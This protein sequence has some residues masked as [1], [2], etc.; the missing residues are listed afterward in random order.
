MGSRSC[1]LVLKSVVQYMDFLK[2]RYFLL[3]LITGIFL[4]G[5]VSASDKKES[6]TKQNVVS[7]SFL[8][9]T[10]DWVHKKDMSLEQKSEISSYS[11]GAY[12]DPSVQHENSSL[13]MEDS[14]LL[15]YSLDSEASSDSS[16]TLKGD[17]QISQG[18]R[19]VFADKALLDQ[20]RRQVSLKGNV[21]FR[22]PGLLLIGDRANIDIDNRNVVM[23]NLTYV[24]HDASL[25]GTAEKLNRTDQGSIIIK[26]ASYSTCEPGDSSWKLV[27]DQIEI[28]QE[29][30]WA[31]IKNARLDVAEIPVFFF[32]YLKVPIN[33]RRV[34]GFLF[35]DISINNKNG[36]DIT[37]PI[38][39]NLAPNYD[40]I[41]SPRI[42]ER[43]GFGLETDLRFLNQWSK[44]T[45]SG[46]F[47]G[48]DRGG[49]DDDKIDPING[50]RPFEGE[51]RYRLNLKHLGG[52]GREWTSYVDFNKVSDLEY[53]RDFGN[54]SIDE[55]SKTHLKQKAYLDYKTPHWSYRIGSEDYQVITQ[56][57]ND[58][59]S[60]LPYISADGYYRYGNNLVINLS[61]QYATFRHSNPTMPEG[62][63]SRI[64]YAMSWDKKWTWGY[65]QPKVQLKHLAYDLRDS[66]SLGEEIDKSP[67]IT[68]PVYSIDM[69]AFF[70]KDSK[71][72]SGFKQTL[73]PRLFYLKSS[74]KDQS[75]MPDFDTREFTP[76]YDLLFED[77]RFVGGDRISDD[78]RLTVGFTTRL[79]D[80]SS[81]EE[82]FRA[83]IAQSIYYADRLVTITMNPDIAEVINMQRNKSVLA[84][85]AA[86]KLNN[87]WRFISDLIYND[88]EHQLE[89]SSLSLRYNDQG[90]KLFNFTYRFTKRVARTYDGQ[91]IDQDIRQSNV[92]AFIP[93]N[94]NFNLV[95]RWNHDFT[96]KRELEVFAGFEY[97]NCCWRASLVARRWL[98]RQDEIILPEQDLRAKNGIAFKI[99]FKGLAGSGSRLDTILKN[100]IYGYEYS[101]SL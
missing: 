92:S 58:Q 97:N 79:L 4:L 11:C 16:V 86:S 33:E 13:K 1:A 30:G 65:I 69:G 53:I 84:I 35:P 82:R 61:N 20:G 77:T 2:G 78:Q 74:Y 70:D 34:S 47:L 44:S 50:L 17:V 83:S 88:D 62:S 72:L 49:A 39:W 93:L 19:Q 27:T 85:Q 10:L 31:T 18:N 100:G 101:E 89:K 23:D 3:A 22:E 68:V 66:E 95:G 63:R 26:N 51:N 56:G 67:E 81:G 42:I 32:P 41:I 9:N 36:L 8:P 12:I 59:Y 6:L 98:D 43:R 46:A 55:T 90:K 38:Y 75:R 87:K 71:W 60:V 64:N 29:A 80:K 96:N 94:S 37:Q 5:D 40:A 28:D 25:R 21:K 14:P 15:V 24:I 48:N 52:L 54:M 57:L 73:E 45:L 99:E 7:K 76:S 91:I